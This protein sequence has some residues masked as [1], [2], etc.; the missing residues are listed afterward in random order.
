MKRSELNKV[1]KHTVA[2]LKKQKYHLPPFAFWSP[3]E[4]AD[5]GHEAD[6]IRE[7][8]LGWDITDFGSGD[9]ERVGLLLFTL[10]NGHNANPRYADKTYCEKMLIA[11][12]SQVTPMH[13]HWSKTEDIINRGGGN[14]EIQL[15]NAT[16]DDRLADTEVEVSMDGV[17]RRYRAGAEVVL[18]PGQSICLP[19]RLYH[20]FWGEAG[21]GT[22]L[23][24]EV[25]K[26]ND[27][28]TDNRFYEPVGR[29]PAIEPDV[30][31]LYLLCWEYPAAQGA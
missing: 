25:S 27:D 31:P 8:M 11:G 2:F 24:G 16:A 26:V 30:K 21:K 23:I 4:W 6:E 18:E 3:E 28:K 7:C 19:S 5:K 15:F 17:R 13:F 1:M 12:E 9:F 29:F 22:V 10:R 14:L 20:K